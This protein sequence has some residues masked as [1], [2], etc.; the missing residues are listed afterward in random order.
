M[1]ERGE[2]LGQAVD[3]VKMALS[4]VEGGLTFG[5]DGGQV[6]SHRDGSVGVLLS[7]R[8]VHRRPDVPQAKPPGPPRRPRPEP[9]RLYKPI[10]HAD[11]RP[12]MRNP[13]ERASSSTF[14]TSGRAKYF[15]STAAATPRSKVRSG[16]R[17]TETAMVPKRTRRK[18]ATR[19]TTWKDNRFRRPIPAM[20]PG[21][22]RGARLLTIPTRVN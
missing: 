20:T 2:D 18:T 4:R 11:P 21:T 10:S 14:R 12:P 6:T 13:S 16:R 17:R 5:N 19:P 3:E 7:V 15:L 9:T 8:Q 22:S 1:T